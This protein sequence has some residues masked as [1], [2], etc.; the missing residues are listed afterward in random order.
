MN[1][2]TITVVKELNN[3]VRDEAKIAVHTQQKV[4]R[5]RDIAKML[6]VLFSGLKINGSET[7]TWFLPSCQLNED[8]HNS[9]IKATIT[10]NGFLR[11]TMGSY[12]RTEWKALKM[13][14]QEDVDI[15][16]GDKARAAAKALTDSYAVKQA[17]IKVNQD[18]LTQK[19]VTEVGAFSKLR[20]ELEKQGII[21]SSAGNG[22]GTI[23]LSGSEFGPRIE[24]L[25]N[26]AR[27]KLVR[28]TNDSVKIQPSLIAAFEKLFAQNSVEIGG[29]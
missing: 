8:D 12:G 9:V 7:E 25:G 17:Q 3:W 20:P 6:K 18:Y 23:L 10:D 13:T 27:L 24:V 19:Q 1:D 21:F 28:Y 15:I 22:G 11:L 26:E 4:T 5:N 29:K 2:F 16:N 14:R